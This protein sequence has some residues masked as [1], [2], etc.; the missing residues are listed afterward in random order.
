[1]S[2]QETPIRLLQNF[3][4]EGSFELV[5]PYFQ[6]H[7]IHLTLT[8][9]R[10]S[11]LGDYRNPT[12]DY[13]YHR[14]SVNINLN[15]YSFLITLLHELAHLLAYVHFKHTISPHGKEWKTQ[16]RH[17]LIPFIGKSFFPND[18]EK[19]LIAYI[20]NPAAS[21]CT[22]PRLFRALYKY[23]EQKPGYKLVEDIEPGQW[24]ETEDGDVYEK[25][26]QLR[27]RSKCKN[28]N[29]G[30]IYLFQGIVEV[31]QVRRDKRRIA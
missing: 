17:V 31:K 4:P 14:I 6:S 10:K 26:E 5:A 3:I 15:K 18:V 29:T 13:P 24:F 22:D 16:F 9:E 20:H 30:K 25:L 21:T 1:M 27:T 11:V 19:A 7:A 8:R 28:L 2:K 12:N 23:D